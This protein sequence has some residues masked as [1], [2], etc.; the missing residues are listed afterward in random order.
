MALVVL[1]A[2]ASFTLSFDALSRLAAESGVV[3]PQRA[4]VFALAVDGAIAVFSISALRAT[5]AGE[6]TRWPMGLVVV[7]TIASIALNMAHTHGGIV[8]WMVAA[9]PPL[10]L[11]LSFES[12]MRQ[13][14]AN[15]RPPEAPRSRRRTVPAARAPCA[16]PSLRTD[17]SREERYARAEALLRE[18]KSRK[19]AAREACIGIGTVRRIASRLAS[20]TVPA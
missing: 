1:L 2:V 15:L 13:L 19:A 17:P 6:R 3:P 9:M 18:G 10:L 7:T 14:A 11:F 20:Q 8:A 12:L 4:C 16:T 5:L